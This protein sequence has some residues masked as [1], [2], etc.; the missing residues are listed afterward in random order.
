M[1]R[2]PFWKYQRVERPEKMEQQRNTA[3]QKLKNLIVK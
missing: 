2:V 3:A 1:D